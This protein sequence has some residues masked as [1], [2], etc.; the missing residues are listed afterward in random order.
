MFVGTK[1]RGSRIYPRIVENHRVDGKIVQ[2]VIA[3][4]GRLDLLQE[5]GRLD[6]LMSSLRRF[7]RITAIPD[8]I[9]GRGNKSR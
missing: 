3:N 2:N 1:S 5:S 4:L 6:S 9:G 7:S 8:K